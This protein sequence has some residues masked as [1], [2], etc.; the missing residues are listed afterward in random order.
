[1]M[2]L[3]INEGKLQK[4]DVICYRA[5]LVR[6]KEV[7]KTG[8][9]VKGPYGEVQKIDWEDILQYNPEILDDSE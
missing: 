8:A 5:N 3:T 7:D 9:V 4:G 1:M 2:R 6:V